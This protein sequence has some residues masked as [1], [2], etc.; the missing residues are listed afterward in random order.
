[1]DGSHF[2]TLAR[3]FA[4]SGTRRRLLSRLLGGVVLGAPL[5]LLGPGDRAAKGKKGHGKK[6]APRGAS[7]DCNAN[8]R[9]GEACQDS[10]QCRGDFRCGAPRLEDQR[11]ECGQNQEAREVCCLGQGDSCHNNN[12]CECC[13]ALSCQQGRCRVGEGTNCA[14]GKVFHLG[15]CIGN[16]ECVPDSEDFL[17]CGPAECG[18]DFPSLDARTICGRTAEGGLVCLGRFVDAELNLP[19]CAQS[20]DC[21]AGRVCQ[22]GILERSIKRCF[23]V[24]GPCVG[25]WC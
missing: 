13:G 20:A 11:E 24:C 10:C 9:R 17:G 22:F 25:S 1:M 23:P 14:P 4:T 12:D 21:A 19:V 3:S 5:V 7:D 8:R 16:E 6:G 15:A 2:D 18:A